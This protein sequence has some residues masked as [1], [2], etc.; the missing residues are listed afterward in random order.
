M[1]TSTEMKKV[2]FSISKQVVEFDKNTAPYNISSTCVRTTKTLNISTPRKRKKKRKRKPILFKIL[3]ILVYRKNVI[4]SRHQLWTSRTIR[5][6]LEV[7]E[8]CQH[9]LTEITTEIQAILSTHEALAPDRRN[10]IWEDQRLEYRHLLAEMRAEASGWATCARRKRSDSIDVVDYLV[11]VLRSFPFSWFVDVF[12]P[13]VQSGANVNADD[14]ADGRSEECLPL[15]A[16]FSKI[17][18]THIE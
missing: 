13:K 11:Y 2:S 7:I 1:A 4:P 16:A 8:R 5:L 17:R 3:G 10:K 6:K 9:N 14:T 18:A 15:P 12:D